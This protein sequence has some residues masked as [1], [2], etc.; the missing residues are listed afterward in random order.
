MENAVVDLFF[1]GQLQYLTHHLHIA[2]P[3]LFTDFA[4]P[5]PD[6]ARRRH[7]LCRF[8]RHTLTDA[9]DHFSKELDRCVGA[10]DVDDGDNRR[11]QG[12]AFQ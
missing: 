4:P 5:L 1:H 7:H 3:V 2:V 8:R 10:R 9:L 11:L 6:V 12:G